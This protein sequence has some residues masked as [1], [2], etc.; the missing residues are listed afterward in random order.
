MEYLLIVYLTV[1]SPEEGEK[2]IE[3]KMPYSTKSKCIKASQKL[4]FSLNF[5]GAKIKTK[6]ECI[7]K[8]Y[9]NKVDGI[10]T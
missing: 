1:I 3:L 5:P 8:N 2:N 6:S 10:E 7:I 9:Y 4:D